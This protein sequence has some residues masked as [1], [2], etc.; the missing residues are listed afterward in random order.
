MTRTGVRWFLI[1]VA[2]ALNVL[3]LLRQPHRSPQFSNPV[4]TPSYA[5]PG[6]ATPFFA[7]ELINPDSPRRMSHVASIC[8]LPDGRL[9]AV[10]YAGSREGA[11]DVA[12][13]FATQQRGQTNWTTPRA[14]LTP[15]LASRELHRRV[16]KVGNAVIFADPAEA[17]LY[18]LYVTITVGGWSGSSLNLT[19]SPDEGQSWTSSQRLTL[20][21]FFNISELVRNRPVPLSDGG[22]L[23]PIYHECI[24]KFP[25]LLW[26]RDTADGFSATKSRIA[27]GRSGFQPALAALSTNTALAF[28]RDCSPRRRVSVART[29]DAA[30]T[31]SSPQALELP[32]PDSG[33]SALRLRDGR[34]LVAFND[35]TAGR[36]NLRLAVSEDQGRT[37]RR[38][39]T[40]EDETGAE[41]SYPYL[42]QGRDGKIHLVYTWKRK[43]IKHVAFNLAWLNAQKGQPSG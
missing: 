43:A 25:E 17:K 31:W 29:D 36:G 10:W 41:F 28:L 26:L 12:I 4:A 18:L 24:G 1:P 35:S 21:P 13:C 2:V 8:E 9:A 19:T 6:Q 42:L 40:L 30:R 3:P 33:L 38:L 16:R 7:E 5:L 11:R 32:N 14:I 39:A 27:G 20:S 34:V 22:W 37:W 23:V 15:E